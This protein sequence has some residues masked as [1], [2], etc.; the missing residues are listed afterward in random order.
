MKIDYAVVSS[1]DNPLYL[2]FW[3]TISKAWHKLDIEPIL[4]YFGNNPPIS[5]YGKVIPMNVYENLSIT[6]CWA[7]Y[8]WVCQQ[9]EKI[10][11]IS[12]I[13]MIPLSRW[14][15]VEQIEKYE[16]NKYLHLNPCIETYSRLPSC[17]HVASGKVFSDFLD[18]KISFTDSLSL[19]LAKKYNN[20]E[21]F[22]PGSGNEF[23]CYDE[24][25][26]TDKILNKH[27]DRFVPINRNGGQ[28]GHRIDRT[29]WN[30]DEQKLKD[31][32]YYDCHSLRPYLEHKNSIDKICK[33]LE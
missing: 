32:Y 9:S 17:Y 19:L 29:D 13:D 14:Y 26:A 15:F 31:G 6:T 16:E 23:W 18:L 25:Y 2:G 30:Y 8:W 27:D 20:K 21:C 33:I 4:L 12:D 5:K 3:D 22:L 10:S 28:S 1:D 24:F 7:R 11:I